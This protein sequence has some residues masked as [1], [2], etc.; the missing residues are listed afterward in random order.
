MTVYTP[1]QYRALAD[2]L[3]AASSCVTPAGSFGHI[4]TVLN[5]A[6]ADAERLREAL[7]MLNHGIKVKDAENAA[8]YV[9]DYLRDGL[10]EAREG[11]G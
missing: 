4:A 7:R 9:R 3:A 1:Q 2:K 11:G 10:T 6:A 8:Y 5:A